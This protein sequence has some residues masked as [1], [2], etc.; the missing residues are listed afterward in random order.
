MTDVIIAGA[1]AGLGVAIPVGAIAVLII[2]TTVRHGFRVG[3]AGGAGA[4][5]VDGS[6]ALLAAFFGTAIAAVLAPWPCPSS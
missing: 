6:Y 1:L 3:W 5:T 4:A 2:E